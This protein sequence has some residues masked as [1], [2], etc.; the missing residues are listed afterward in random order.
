MSYR[1][2]LGSSLGFVKLETNAFK[3]SVRQGLLNL[4]QLL[5]IN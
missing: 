3:V 5:A 1:K 2:I 4:N